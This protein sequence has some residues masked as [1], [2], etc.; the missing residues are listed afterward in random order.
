MTPWRCSRRRS[1]RCVAVVPRG[2]GP[3]RAGPRC[4]PR[5]P[6][7]RR[8]PAR[9]GRHRGGADAALGR[10]LAAAATTSL[11]VVRACPLVLPRLARA[12]GEPERGDR[13]ARPAPDRDV[14]GGRRGQRGDR[15]SPSSRSTRRW[16]PRSM[17]AS[18]AG[19]C[20]AAS[21]ACWTVCGE[22]RSSTRS[23][24]RWP[25]PPTPGCRMRRAIAARI[26]AHDPLRPPA[27]VTRSVSA[28]QAHLDGLGLLQPLLEDPAVTDVLVNGPGPVWVERA[29][30]LRRDAGRARPSADRARWS[31]GSWRRSGAGPT[32]CTPWST[33]ASP[34]GRASTWWCRRSRSTGR[35]SPSG[36]S[37]CGPSRWMPSPRARWR[38]CCGWAVGTR[39]NVVV[40]GATGSGQ[41]HA[42]QRARRSHRPRR[43]H[44]HRRGRGRAPP[45]RAARRPAREP[46]GARP[47]ERRRSPSG[48]W[49]A[50]RCGCGPTA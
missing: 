16:R 19:R 12:P 27:E 4:G 34:T 36:A 48:T 26:R 15:S 28:I 49:C 45:R 25:A 20:P 6:A 39:C 37:P 18:P 24:G 7:R 9:G 42:A 1:A 3:L 21:C 50:T 32:R 43:A 23:T 10:E 44:H 17:P 41:D 29:G 33:P 47:T 38:S 31:N 2:R 8:V 40:S 11:L 13:R 35:A 14:A 22:R 5:P 46:A 30:R